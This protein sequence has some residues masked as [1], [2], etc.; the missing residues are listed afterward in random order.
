MALFTCNIVGLSPSSVPLI[1]NGFD[2]VGHQRGVTVKGCDAT[3]H[4]SIITKLMHHFL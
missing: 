4:F 3:E 2:A 1:S